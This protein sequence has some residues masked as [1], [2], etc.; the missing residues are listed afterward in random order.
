MKI[1]KNLDWATLPGDTVPYYHKIKVAQ[2][3]LIAWTDKSY[4]R[5]HSIQIFDIKNFPRHFT[6][7]T[8]DTVG[9]H[10]VSPQSQRPNA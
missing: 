5:A 3:N 1:L 6:M 7:I 10:V 2:K 9:L 8:T 4:F